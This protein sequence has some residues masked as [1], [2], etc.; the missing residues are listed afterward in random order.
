MIDRLNLFKLGVVSKTSALIIRCNPCGGHHAV[1][2]VVHIVT[3]N[4]RLVREICILCIYSVRRKP[5]PLL[6]QRNDKL[7]QDTT[8]FRDLG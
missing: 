4:A 1:L 5:W 3:E 7:P 2:Y 6:H 8:T